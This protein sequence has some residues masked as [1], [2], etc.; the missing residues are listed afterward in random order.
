MS[1]DGV[2][3]MRPELTQNVEFAP[4]SIYSMSRVDILILLVVP[5]ACV[6]CPEYE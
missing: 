1:D 4:A 6:L 5:L 2:T 3:G